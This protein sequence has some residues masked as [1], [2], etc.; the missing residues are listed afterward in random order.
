MSVNGCQEQNS[1][2][3]DQPTEI[4]SINHRETDLRQWHIEVYG[5]PKVVGFISLPH[6]FKYWA[7]PWLDIHD[8]P[9][10]GSLAPP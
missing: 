6:G 9:D 7:P 10:L 1:N 3:E 8:C 2:L 5:H 4:T